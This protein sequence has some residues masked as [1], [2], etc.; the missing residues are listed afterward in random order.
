MH[1]DHID[2]SNKYLKD[3]LSIIREGISQRSNILS[4]NKR[5]GL[6]S[7]SLVEA[8]NI[9][10]TTFVICNTWIGVQKE[11]ERENSKSREDIYFY[12][13]DDNYTRIFYV[14]AKRLPKHQTNSEEEYVFGQSTSG[15]PSGGIQR[16][17]RNHG[18][19]NIRYNGMIAYVENKSVQDWLNIV[20]AKIARLYPNDHTLSETDHTYEYTST[21]FYE[22]GIGEFLMYHF[23]IDLTK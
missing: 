21:H 16:Y 5:E 17:K 3:I 22:T 15:S 11:H 18:D 4:K 1:F 13:N 20:N 14:E 2:Y 23:W 8:F 9:I 10:G 6:N 19:C 12:L 7:Q